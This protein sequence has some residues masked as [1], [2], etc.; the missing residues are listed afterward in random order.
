M[1][2]KIGN[3]EGQLAALW[4]AFW[5]KRE[6]ITMTGAGISVNVGGELL[7][8]LRQEGYQLIVSSVPDFRTL[9]DGKPSTEV[10]DISV[11]DSDEP[12]ERFRTISVK[13]FNKATKAQPTAFNHLLSSLPHY[14]RRHRLH[15]RPTYR[16]P[17]LLT[18]SGNEIFL[19]RSLPA[20][21]SGRGNLI[22]PARDLALYTMR[23]TPFTHEVTAAEK[24]RT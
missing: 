14:H 9:C 2:S 15:L 17:R 4:N 13:L 12:T 19:F 23:S 11:Y 16:L 22:A 10:F 7:F 6:P 1:H 5:S 8:H 18:W 3:L 24:R 21:T 20:L